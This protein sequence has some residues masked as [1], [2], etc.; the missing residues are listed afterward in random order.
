MDDDRAHAKGAIVVTGAGRGIG[1]RTAITL[2]RTGSPIVAVYRSRTE[3]AEQVATAIRDAGGRVL[4]VRADVAKEEDVPRIFREAKDA[5]GTIAG[6]VNNAATNGGR[7]RL[8]ELQRHQLEETFQTN[9]YGSFLCAR[10]AV[11]LMSAS[12]GGAGGA[13][14]NVSSGASRTGSPGVWVHYAASK[15]AIETMTVGLARELASEGV[16]VNAVRCGVID[17][18][19]HQGHGADR[20]QQLMAMVPMKRMGQPDEV[21]GAIAFLMSEAAS[22]VTGAVLDVAGGL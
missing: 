22:Y 11:R 7:A 4:L 5:F 6:L 21:A 3:D 8:T 2:A 18:D 10:E 14:V 15:A 16:R 13:I 12:S 20:L 1:A 19:V 9:V 17:T